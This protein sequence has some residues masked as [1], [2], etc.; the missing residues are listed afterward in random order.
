MSVY[1]RKALKEDFKAVA[2]LY[3]HLQD[4]H[5][6]AHPE[7]YVLG[8]RVMNEPRFE[9]MLAAHDAQLFVADENGKLIGATFV[10]FKDLSA[11][12]SSSIPASAEIEAVVV[13]PAHQ[14]HGVAQNMIAVAEAWAEKRGAS[15]IHLTTHE[16]NVNAQK[17]YRK[18]GYHT[19]SLNMG[20]F[21][22]RG[23]PHV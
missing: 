16:S 15:Y 1:V 7:L 9:K 17:S 2:D 23:A 6:I 10:T 21:L 19:E 22:K 3:Q 13:D 5:A 18:A 4:T 20:K 11:R 12:A 14:G 8:A